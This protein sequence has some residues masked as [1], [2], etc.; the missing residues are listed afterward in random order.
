MIKEAE[1]YAEEDRKRREAAEL[2]NQAD[3][4]V[5]QTEKFLADNPDTVPADVKSEVERD[6]AEVKKALEGDDTSA[7]KAAFDKLSASRTKIGQAI[8]ANAQ[9]SATA[10]ESGGTSAS[11]SGKDDED[12][13]EAEIVDEDKPS[14]EGQGGQK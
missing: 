2:R 12:V 10:G 9:Q 4:L 3:T 8:Y 6:I 1:Q 11:A 7:L 5:Y 13:V 14:D